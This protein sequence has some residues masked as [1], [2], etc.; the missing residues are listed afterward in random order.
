MFVPDY[1]GEFVQNPNL[2][3]LEQP[4]RFKSKIKPHLP[5]G[6]V[7]QRYVESFWHQFGAIIATAQIESKHLTAKGGEG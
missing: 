2:P 7:G 1:Q 4:E 3:S 5:A 6:S